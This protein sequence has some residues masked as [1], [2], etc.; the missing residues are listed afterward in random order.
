MNLITEKSDA[1]CGEGLT[2]LFVSPSPDFV[3]KCI[4]KIELIFYFFV[5]FFLQYLKYRILNIDRQDL[6]YRILNIDIQD[7]KYCLNM[8]SIIYKLLV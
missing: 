7:L 1:L 3:D 5:L 8:P 6:K 2:D 4:V